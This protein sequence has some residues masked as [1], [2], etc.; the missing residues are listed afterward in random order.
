MTFRLDSTLTPDRERISCGVLALASKLSK[1]FAFRAAGLG[2]IRRFSAVVNSGG[3][4]S[5]APGQSQ[6]Y[7]SDTS[8]IAFSLPHPIVRIMRSQTNIN[9]LNWQ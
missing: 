4:T 7:G 2:M 1:D 5:C 8:A 3:A 6:G 9:S